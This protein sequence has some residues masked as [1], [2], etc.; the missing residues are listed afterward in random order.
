MSNVN[1][2]NILSLTFTLFHRFYS[3]LFISIK[4]EVFPSDKYYLKMNELV[5]II[6]AITD[7]EF[8]MSS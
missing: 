3:F 4:I 2:S 1:L 5:L 8:C 7:D 6:L